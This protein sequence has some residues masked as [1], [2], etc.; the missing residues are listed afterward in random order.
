MVAAVTARKTLYDDDEMCVVE[1]ECVLPPADFDAFL[2]YFSSTKCIL[3]G[4]MEQ[5]RLA[6]QQ[7]LVDNEQKVSQSLTLFLS[8]A[9]IPFILYI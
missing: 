5:L 4:E 7:L 2:A 3:A 9:D 6:V 8:I 1:R